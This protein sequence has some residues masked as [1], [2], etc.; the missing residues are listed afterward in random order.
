MNEEEL[1][2]RLLLL[3]VHLIGPIVFK[4]LIQE[5]GSAK[6]IFNE[7][8]STLKKIKGI[9]DAIVS[10]LQLKEHEERVEKELNYISK[11]NIEVI[12]F[13][14]DN[15][16]KK[17]LQCIDSPPL[18]F[19]KGKGLI[20]YERSISII[21]T[22]NNTD[23]GKQ[24]TEQI[25][26]DLQ[27]YNVQIVS[28][29]AYG[30]DVIA[31]KQALKNSMS[32]IGVVAHGLDTLYPSV[33]QT[34]ANEMLE[35]GGLLSEYFTK[36][37]PDRENFPT[38]NRI[39]AGMT[40]ATLVIETDI[41]GGSMITA[42]IA[43][44]YNKDVFSIPGRV[45]DKY[46]SGNN[47]LIKN[48]KANLVTSADDI[49]YHLGWI[50]PDIVKPLQKKLFIE[51]TENESLIVNILEQKTLT[52]IDEI[53]LQSNLKSSDIANAILQLELKDLVT[54]LPGKMHKLS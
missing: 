10:Q 34:V 38:R 19:Y 29:L 36:T 27:K 24:I 54:V 13:T 48:L 39:V 1:K 41:K 33:H 9:G 42:E 32:T 43:N 37:K 16:P 14:E 26:K 53:V 35:N 50:K 2:F 30:I 23:Y 52:H 31:H 4:K 7:K 40:D 8:K 21:G 47:I 12:H 5:V 28:G 3:Q 11:N 17:L 20:N 44:G 46:S 49:A 18:L 51:L 15:Y 6:A 45:G 25:I 22:R